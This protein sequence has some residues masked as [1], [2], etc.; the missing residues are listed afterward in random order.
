MRSKFSTQP[1]AAI[2]LLLPIL[3]SS[4]S[5]CGGSSGEP[6]KDP[7]SGVDDPSVAGDPG[8]GG[9]N[10]AGDDDDGVGKSAASRGLP[11][12]CATREGDLC[13]PPK[14]FALALCDGDYRSVALWMFSAGSPWTRGYLLG[15]IKAV[16]ASA[17]GGSTGEMMPRDEEVIVVRHHGASNPGG[18]VVS[19]A[20]GAYD[21]VRWDG[22]CATIDQ[23][24][25]SFD[26]PARPLN[27]RLIWSRI[28]M[29]VR[30]VL[31]EDETVYDAYILLKK[32][33]KGVTMGEVSKACEKADGSLSKILAAHVRTKGGVPA[34]KKIPEL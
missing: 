11:S 29:D 23:G 34:P 6:P 13:L 20:S 3:V 8:N 5:A 16:Y 24:S 2:L 31:K 26:P 28:E 25:L 7:Q 33:C 19:G 30:E 1:V 9:E 10:A 32:T 14:K 17:S 18:I 21:V 22:S 15:K 4:Q 12:D 27:A